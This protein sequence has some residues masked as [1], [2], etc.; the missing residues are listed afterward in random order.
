MYVTTV[1][2]EGLRMSRTRLDSFSAI[3]VI[4]FASLEGACDKFRKTL[5]FV[6]RT[7]ANIIISFLQLIFSSTL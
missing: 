6:L 3:R 1:P 2:L 4:F 7:G 5:E